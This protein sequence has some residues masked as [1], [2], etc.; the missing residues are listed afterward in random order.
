MF[1]LTKTQMEKCN[2]IY[3]D[4]DGYWAILKPEYRL[5]D[6]YGER[7]IHEDDKKSFN[8]AFRYVVRS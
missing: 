6:Y 2:D 7:T 3:H 5:E 8:D 4:E 1:G